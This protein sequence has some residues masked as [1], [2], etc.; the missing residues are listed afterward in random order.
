MYGGCSKVKLVKR[1]FRHMVLAHDN[2]KHFAMHNIKEYIHLHEKT[3][4]FA[5][6]AYFKC[7]VKA[8]QVTEALFKAQ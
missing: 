8:W 5:K 7:T 2:Y 6:L 1:N 4:W 3:L